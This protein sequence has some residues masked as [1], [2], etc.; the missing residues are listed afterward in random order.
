M[1]SLVFRA[2]R[3]AAELICQNNESFLDAP[4]I[5]WSWNDLPPV[6]NKSGAKYSAWGE[7]SRRYSHS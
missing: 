6:W 4:R 2:V 7:P 3:A 5:A 1:S